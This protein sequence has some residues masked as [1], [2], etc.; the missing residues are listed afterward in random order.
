LS[1]SLVYGYGDVISVVPETETLK[2][3]QKPAKAERPLVFD[4]TKYVQ[5]NG[6][7][8]PNCSAVR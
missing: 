8:S 3:K 6:P 7:A 4:E 1:I 5:P 2:K